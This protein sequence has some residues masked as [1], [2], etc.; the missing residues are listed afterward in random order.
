MKQ[1]FAFLLLIGILLSACGPA[2]TEAPASPTITARPVSTRTP[3][4]AASASPTPPP[5]GSGQQ[6]FILS[7]HDNGYNHLF[8]YSPSSLNMT[9][10]TDGQWDDIAPSISPDGTRVAFASNRNEY[11]DIYLLDL[12]SGQTSRLTDTPEYDSTPTWSPDSQWIVFE[13]YVDDNLEIMIKSTVD[14]NIPVIRLTN[15]PATDQHPTWS[16]QGRLIAFSS[17]RSGEFEIWLASL[18]QP[19]DDRYIN[20]SNSPLRDD[21]HPTWSPDGNWLAWDGVSPAEPESIYL[22]DYNRPGDPARRV[23]PGGW[24]AWNDNGTQ[25]AA[26]L[27]T[28]NEDYLVAYNTNGTFSLPAVPQ[29]SIRGLDWRNMPNTA[30]PV[31]FSRAALASPTP[32]WQVSIEIITDLPN[33]RSSIVRMENIQ[34]PHPYLH[35]EINES[36]TALRNRV[37]VETG[38]DALANLENAY[39]PLTSTLDPGNNEGWLYTGRAFALNPVLLN[40]GWMVVVRDDLDGRTYWRLF[41]RTLAQDGSQGEPLRNRPWDL[42]ARYNLDPL[43]YEQGGAY[44]N[45]IP[46]GYWL[47]FTDLA[48]QYGWERQPAQTNWRTYFNGVQFNEFVITGGLDWRSAMLQLYPFD[49]LVTPTAIIPATRTPTPTPT[50]YR[51]RSPTPTVTA[52]ETPRPTFTPAP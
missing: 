23:A 30:L 49:I 4:P 2:P 42:N 28:P 27:S 35:D 5:P 11:W 21:S 46:S 25:L 33:N 16:P 47:D 7:L 6:T 10:L 39:V 22:W 8:A 51:Y 9:R 32:L 52:T 50:G 1:S 34:A 17:N 12:V 18:D 15:H 24:P 13:S 20:L 31:I 3:T 19:S 45:E 36:F 26:R 43:A 40:A 48:R 14:A 41:L 38:W 37:I 44:F 29:Q